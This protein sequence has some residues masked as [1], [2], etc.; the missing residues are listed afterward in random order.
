MLHLGG[1]IS[2]QILQIDFSESVKICDGMKSCSNRRW[3]KR[4]NLVNVPCETR[5]CLQGARVAEEV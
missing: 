5:E 3:A 2:P 4:E 1:S